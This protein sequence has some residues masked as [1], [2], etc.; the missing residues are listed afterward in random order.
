M[1]P[2]ADRPPWLDQPVGAQADRLGRRPKPNYPSVAGQVLFQSLWQCLSLVTNGFVHWSAS[3][4]IALTLRSITSNGGCS[5]TD[6]K[7]SSPLLWVEYRVGIMTVL[8][9]RLPSGT[10]K[11]RTRNSLRRREK[12]GSVH[13]LKLAG[14]YFCWWPIISVHPAK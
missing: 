5:F 2:W 11:I 7:L 1:K 3:T 6:R 14:L 12:N 10:L 13:C 8:R 4:T 9:L